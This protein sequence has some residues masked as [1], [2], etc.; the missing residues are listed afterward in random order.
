MF[1]TLGKY[2]IWAHDRY[3]T[4]FEKLSDEEFS[5]KDEMVGFSIRSM[6]E[7]VIMVT[8]YSIDGEDSMMEWTEKAMEAEK[9]ELLSIWKE[10]DL[11]FAEKIKDMDP[12]KKV[13]LVPITGE[14]DV[15]LRQDEFFLIFSDHMTFHRGQFLS[16]MKH[17]GKPGI[18]SDFYY[19]VLENRDEIQN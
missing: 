2:Y 10:L 12:A 1:D 15:E 7:H 11:E 16:L 5:Q 3:R 8:S 18:S 4:E 6:L 17:L 19:Y 9:N 13:T 14:D